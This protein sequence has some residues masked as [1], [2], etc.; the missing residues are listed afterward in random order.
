MNKLVIIGVAAVVVLALAG[1]A[2]FYFIGGSAD[3]GMLEGE[4]VTGEGSGTTEV[5]NLDPPIYHGLDPDFVIAFQNPKNVRFVKASIEVMVRDEDV[6]EALKLH[7][8]AVRDAIIMLFSAKTEDELML[9]ADKE[10]FRAEILQTI[11]NTLEQL[12]GSPG[13]EAVYFSN[14]VMQ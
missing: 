9:P 11:R 1:G 14:F 8:P 5:A 4:A 12:T 6:I 2:A 7:M 3:E 13:V 10:K